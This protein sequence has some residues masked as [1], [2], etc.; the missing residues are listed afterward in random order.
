MFTENLRQKL[1]DSTAASLAN[2][3]NLGRP[4]VVKR[5]T[6]ILFANYKRLYVISIVQKRCARGLSLR[7]SVRTN[8]YPEIM[9]K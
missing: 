2:S 3:V 9:F 4:Q 5:P 6:I 7:E 8:S 1:T